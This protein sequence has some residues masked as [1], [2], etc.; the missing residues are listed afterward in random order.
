M[1]AVY[2]II[3]KRSKIPF[4]WKR[5]PEIG[6]WDN[7]AETNSTTNTYIAARDAVGVVHCVCSWCGRGRPQCHQSSHFWSNA[8]L[9]AA[10]TEM[11]DTRPS[12][13]SSQLTGVAVQCWRIRHESIKT[14]KVISKWPIVIS[15]QTRLQSQ[16]TISWIRI[17]AKICL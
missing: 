8:R 2:V 13:S 4:V 9:D 11:L 1:R 7:A 17:S 14:A 16:W 5:S 10:V 3:R 12:S 15:Q 6:V